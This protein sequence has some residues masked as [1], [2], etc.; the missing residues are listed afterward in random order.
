MRLRQILASC[1]LLCWIAGCSAP[2]PVSLETPSPAGPNSGQPNLTSGPDEKVYLSWLETSEDGVRALK[3]ARWS[4]SGWEEPRTITD[5]TNLL[6]NWA[7]FPS[8]VALGNGELGAHWLTRMPD[9]PG[10]DVQI[11]VSADG[12]ISWSPQ[13]TPHRDATATEHGFVS[14]AGLDDGRLSALWLDGRKLALDEGSDEV[15]LLQTLIARDGAIGAET[16]VDERVCECCAPSS[17][18][19]RGEIFTVYRDR[20]PDEIRDIVLVRFKD[21]SWSAPK[22][23]FADNW[24]ILACPINGPAIAANDGLIAVAWFTAPEGKPRVKVAF[25]TDSGESFTTPVVVDD[26]NPVGRVDVAMLSEQAVVTWIE[27]SDAGGQVRVKFVG[28]DGS[29]QDSVV[30]APTS[31]GTASGFPRIERSGD[32]AIV[33]WTDSG[34]KRVKTATV[35]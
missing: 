25:S 32:S 28:A 20:S 5:G 18:A 26:G 33:A 17:V 30:I 34:E 23:V 24:K 22:S 31:I 16:V 12:G 2:A 13:T 9:A 8:L 14:F 7:D 10:Y 19:V 35:R 3:F 15:A 6:S 21:G 11:S 1:V 27:H 29:A 4:G